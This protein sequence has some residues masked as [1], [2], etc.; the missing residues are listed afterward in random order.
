MCRVATTGNANI[1]FLL[2]A[3]PS[4]NLEHL[5][6]VER[7]KS[8]F[9]VLWQIRKYKRYKYPLRPIFVTLPN[10][11]NNRWN[12]CQIS[13]NSIPAFP[14]LSVWLNRLLKGNQFSQF[15]WEPC[16]T[17][18]EATEATTEYFFPKPS[19][20][21]MPRRNWVWNV[22]RSWLYILGSTALHFTH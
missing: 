6:E 2:L 9:L 20:K 19:E 7:H 13:D 14:A 12:S 11:K 21:V 22:D 3:P 1:P 18:T 5:G 16:E 4:C 17:V 10:T 8:H 15:A